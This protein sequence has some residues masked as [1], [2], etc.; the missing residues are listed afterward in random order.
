MKSL[1]REVSKVVN[2]CMREALVKGVAN[3]TSGFLV[4]QSFSIRQWVHG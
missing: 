4:K 1:L 3:F 2:G